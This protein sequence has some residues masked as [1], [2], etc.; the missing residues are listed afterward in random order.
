MPLRH[1]PKLQLCL[2]DEFRA[3]IIVQFKEKLMHADNNLFSKALKF[4]TTKCQNSSVDITNLPI[5]T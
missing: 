1:C 4:P 2:Y 5:L 3:E